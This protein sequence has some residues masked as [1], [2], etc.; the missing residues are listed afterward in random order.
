M[1]E[2]TATVEAMDSIRET[3]NPAI[4]QAAFVSALNKT[5]DRGVTAATKT[6]TET[7]NIKR[8]DLWSTSTGR[9][10]IK[11]YPARRGSLEVA[12]VLAGRSISLSYFGAV[13]R[14]GNRVITRQGTK[15]LKR[16]PRNAPAGVTVEVHRGK[17]TILPKAFIS[18]VQAGR[19]GTHVGVWMRRTSARD[20]LIDKR[21]PTVATLFTGVRASETFRKAV[22]MHFFKIFNHELNFRAKRR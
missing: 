7:Y 13:Q 8:R 4:Y 10:R 1:T 6:V 15:T 12:V 19:T 21:I 11:I 5:T 3:L 14:V 16:T 2:F 20:S 17:R 18:T 22:D 9:S